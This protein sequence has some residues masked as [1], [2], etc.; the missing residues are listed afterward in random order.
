MTNATENRDDAQPA[1]TP[2]D[3]EVKAMLVKEARVLGH[4]EARTKPH[5]ALAK[6]LAAGLVLKSMGAIKGGGHWYQLGPKADNDP[7]PPLP[8]V[9]FTLGSLGS[10]EAYDLRHITPERY[11]VGEEGTLAFKHPDKG[12]A[13]DGWVFVEVDSK[14][15]EPRKLYV[16]VGPYMYERV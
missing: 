2:T 9:R 13:A 14:I 10:S 15:G 12:L 4:C 8:R 1:P 5:D 11:H 3:L 6:A 16:G 7:G